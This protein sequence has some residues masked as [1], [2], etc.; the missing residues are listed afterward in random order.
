[1]HTKPKL[2][3]FLWGISSM[4]KIEKIDTKRGS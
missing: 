3:E 4:L 2:L 1:M